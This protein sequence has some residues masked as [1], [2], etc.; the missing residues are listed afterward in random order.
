MFAGNKVNLKAWIGS[1]FVQSR[2]WTLGLVA[3][4]CL[5]TPIDL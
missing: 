1:K 2:P 4:D 3:L 5:K